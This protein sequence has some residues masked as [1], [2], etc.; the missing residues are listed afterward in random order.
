MTDLLD[1]PALRALDAVISYK[2]FQRAAAALH[3]TQSAISQRIKTLEDKCGAP[4]L[5][6]ENPPKATSLG[7]KLISHLH[8]VMALENELSESLGEDPN[9]VSST[10]L[11]GV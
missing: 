2:G 5:S 11:I 3:I 7:K 9:A 8:S 10:L 4:L 6:R 1:Y